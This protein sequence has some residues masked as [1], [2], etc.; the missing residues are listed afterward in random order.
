M[1]D[2]SIDK[3]IKNF[4]LKDFSKGEEVC[5]RKLNTIQKIENLNHVFVDDSCDKV[6]GAAHH[7]VIRRPGVEIG[8]DNY[9]DYD[10]IAHI[11]FQCGARTDENSKVGVIDT[12]LLEIVRDRLKGFQ[13]GDFATEDNAEALKHIEIA[14]MYMNKRVMDRYERNVLGTYEK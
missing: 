12:D 14:L 10:T 4:E 2:I 1:S 13:N 7:Y 6:G 11:E 5:M 9:P 8:D 3:V